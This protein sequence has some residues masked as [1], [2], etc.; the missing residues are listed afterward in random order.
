MRAPAVLG[1]LVC[2]GLASAG[3]DRPPLERSC[4]GEVVLACDPY[5]YAEIVSATLEPTRIS[6]GDPR[7]FATVRVEL[8]T[9]GDRVPVAPEVQLAALVS[10]AGGSF[11]LDASGRD[12][13]PPGDG[14]R[15][16]QLASVRAGATTDTVIERTIDN[17]FDSRIPIDSDITLRFAPVIG[18]CEGEALE[19]PYRTG[20][21]PSP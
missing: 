18:G 21:R 6:P 9:C 13:G 12:V 20:P 7:G 19:I 17:P 4:G 10:G 8:R 5:E 1:T 16:Y 11:P 15:L 2:L 14:T 3:C